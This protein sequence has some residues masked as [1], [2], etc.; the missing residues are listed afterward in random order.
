MKRTDARQHDFT[1]VLEQRARNVGTA[2][3][4]ERRCDRPLVARADLVSCDGSARL[5]ELITRRDHGD[6]R[7]SVD[8]DFGAPGACENCHLGRV[9]HRAGLEQRTAGL[10]VGSLRVYELPCGDLEV[11]LDVSMLTFARDSLDGNDGIGA[12]G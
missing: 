9:Q 8:L 5:D 6:A 2:A 3:A 10:A 7:C 12:G 4:L 11:R 1:L